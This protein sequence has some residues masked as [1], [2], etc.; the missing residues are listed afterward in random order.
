MAD[1]QFLETKHTSGVYYK[2]DITIVRGE[3][4]L[5]WDQHGQEYIDCVAGQGVALSLIHI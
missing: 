1:S 4:A 3:G 2:R 5:V